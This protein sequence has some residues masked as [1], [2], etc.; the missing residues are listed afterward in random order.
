MTIHRRL[1][2]TCMTFRF[3]EVHETV[4]RTAASLQWH[5]G[6][7]TPTPYTRKRHLLHSSESL[8]STEPTFVALMHTHNRLAVYYSSLARTCIIIVFEY[9]NFVFNFALH[10]FLD[11]YCISSFVGNVISQFWIESVPEVLFWSWVSLSELGTVDIFRLRA[12]SI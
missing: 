6:S 9:K 10:F 1:R 5:S 2:S 3:H 7:A 4:R 8:P 11:L 12:T